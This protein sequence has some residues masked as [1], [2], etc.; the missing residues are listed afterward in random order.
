MTLNVN[1]KLMITGM[2]LKVTTHLHLIP[3]ARIR[4]VVPPLPAIPRHGV[5]LS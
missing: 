5:M 1:V 3:R 4:G 2:W